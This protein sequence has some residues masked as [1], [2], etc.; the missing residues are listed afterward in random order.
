MDA[1]LPH[2][3]YTDLEKFDPNKRWELI[4]GIPYAMSSPTLAHQLLVGEL[5]LALRQHFK[6]GP[7][8]VILAP[9][10]VKISDHNVVQP[11]LLVSCTDRLQFHYHEGAPELAIEVL[12]QSTLRHDRVRKLNLYARS[13]VQEYWMVTPH[14]LLIEVLGNTGEGFLVR[15][16][17]TQ[18][19]KLRSFV[20]PELTIDLA[21]LLAALPPQPPIEGEVRETAPV[22]AT[23]P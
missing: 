5:Y 15:G 12:S 4:D 2:Y 21:Q 17:F 20:F 10:D 22:Y 9:F 19:D 1:P 18:D 8:K 7:C 3:T 16:S 6:K 23:T 13:G 11:D 14:P